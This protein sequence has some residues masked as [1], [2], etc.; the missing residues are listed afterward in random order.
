LIV[1]CIETESFSAMTHNMTEPDADPTKNGGITNYVLPIIY[2]LTMVVA[3]SVVGAIQLNRSLHPETPAEQLSRAVDAIH[4]GENAIARRVLERL[5]AGG[6][7]DAEY[8]LA[9]LQE[10]GLGTPKDTRKAVSLLDAAA[11]KGFVPAQVRLGE[12]Y[13]SGIQIDPDYG[14]A[15]RLLSGAAAARSATAQRLLGQMY[16]AALSGPRDPFKAAVYF[17]A[18]A[19]NGDSLAVSELDGVMLELSP[20]QIAQIPSEITR[21]GLLK[22]G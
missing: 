9:D 12:L 6:N 5:A 7:A 14:K 19:G 22:Q 15:M 10:H 16:A 3:L 2:G 20:A 11:A 1:L 13:L 4:T 18:A 8:W 17:S 21:L